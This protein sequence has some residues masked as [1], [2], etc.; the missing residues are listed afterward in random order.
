MGIHDKGHELWQRG[1]RG[2]QA[3]KGSLENFSKHFVPSFPA[4][5]IEW[6]AYTAV[7]QQDES[8]H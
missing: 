1:R 2:R 7:S 8:L 5:G 6:F 4:T 3:M